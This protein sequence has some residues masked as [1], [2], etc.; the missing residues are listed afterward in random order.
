MVCGIILRP[1]TRG[2]LLIP[3][4]PLPA[5]ATRGGPQ[6]S[7]VAQ[8]WALRARLKVRARDGGWYTMKRIEYQNNMTINNIVK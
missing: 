8:P 6:A 7:C 3:V 4:Q 5:V 2:Y 1:D